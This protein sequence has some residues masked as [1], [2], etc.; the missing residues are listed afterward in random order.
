MPQLGR[1]YSLYHIVSTRRTSIDLSAKYN[2]PKNP[3]SSSKHKKMI[4]RSQVHPRQVKHQHSRS[5]SRSSQANKVQQLSSLSVNNFTQTPAAG[6][7]EDSPR[8]VTL[9]EKLTNVRTNSCRQRP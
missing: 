8:E 4:N 1:N 6:S 7:V 9:L 3:Q 5:S 2:S